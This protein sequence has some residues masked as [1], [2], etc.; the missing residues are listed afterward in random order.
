MAGEII[1]RA[2]KGLPMLGTA[3]AVVRGFSPAI[4][5]LEQP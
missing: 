4:Q 3:Q 5:S 1:T 2:R